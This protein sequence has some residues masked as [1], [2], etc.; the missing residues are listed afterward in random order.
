MTREGGRYVAEFRA[1]RAGPPPGEWRRV[2][3]D[4]PAVGGSAVAAAEVAGFVR[5][6][7]A[8]GWEVEFYPAAE[9]GA[10]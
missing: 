4:R 5:H 3:M 10:A 9:G 6:L 8:S 1:R 2:R 7:L